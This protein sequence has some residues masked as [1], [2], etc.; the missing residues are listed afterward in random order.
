MSCFSQTSPGRTHLILNKELINTSV[1]RMRVPVDLSSASAALVV[2]PA[3]YPLFRFEGVPCF[4]E[5][6]EVRADGR[7]AE[8]RPPTLDEILHSVRTEYFNEA[9]L[10]EGPLRLALQHE[11]SANLTHDSHYVHVEVPVT[12]RQLAATSF[13][14]ELEQVEDELIFEEQVLDKQLAML[15]R[16]IGKRRFLHRPMGR[17]QREY[18]SVLTANRRSSEVKYSM[19]TGRLSARL[20]FHRFGSNGTSEAGPNITDANPDDLPRFC[21]FRLAWVDA[22][23]AV[24]P[25][26][27]DRLR[28]EAHRCPSHDLFGMNGSEL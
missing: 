19:S 11:V 10:D 9:E 15:L 25:G 24:P 26:A 23:A 8:L 21:P 7:L 27:M 14:Y 22:M 20:A 12:L 5:E 16:L 4:V 3:A 18:I 28:I 17:S 1:K 2:S 13:F 6:L